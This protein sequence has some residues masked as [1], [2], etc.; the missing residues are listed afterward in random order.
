MTC[1]GRFQFPSKGRPEPSG[2]GDLVDADVPAAQSVAL[3]Y[4]PGL[5][6]DRLAREDLLACSQREGLRMLDL[7]TYEGVRL[8]VLDETTGMKTGT[9]KS[10]DGCIS[11][12]MCRKLGIRRAAFSSGANTGLALTDY[13]A[14]IGLESFFFCPTDTLYKLDG[15]LFERPS[16]HLIA[17]DGGAADRR[18]KEAARL[19]AEALEIPLIPPLEWRM[20]STAC[21]G[22]FIAEWIL[23]H[24]HARPW[25]TQA[26]CAGY[27]P[28]GAYQVLRGLAEAGRLDPGRI[29]RF[30]GFQQA[31]LCPMVRAWQAGRSDLAAS[32]STQ[33]QEHP[34]EPGLY[35]ARPVQTY[36]LLYDLLTHCDGDM[37]AVSRAEFDEHVEEFV[38][39][40]KAVGIVPT[41]IPGPGE[42]QYLERAGLLAGAGTIKAVKDGRIEKG[43][44]VICALT[45]G[46]GPMPTAPA[47]PEYRIRADTSV[48][49]AVRQLAGTS[50]FQPTRAGSGSR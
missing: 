49:Q 24:D 29:P 35:N 16:A 36:P 44:T 19:F 9:Y 47:E 4:A 11:S 23:A 15:G 12:A 14:K 1:P 32:T 27:G 7:G 42:T 34:I 17:V 43:Q 33:W 28:I 31:A 48:A 40:L 37:L 18:V 50:C 8:F 26:V 3:R 10:L 30:M 38:R 13:A 46:A 25:L 22:L 45:G 6:S 5:L 41:R 20:L 21:R 2:L 39:L